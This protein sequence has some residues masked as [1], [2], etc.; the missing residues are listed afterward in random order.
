MPARPALRGRLGR[1]RRTCQGSRPGHSGSGHACAQA[2]L[3]SQ[4]ARAHR[5]SDPAHTGTVDPRAG[6]KEEARRPRAEEEGKEEIGGRE[7]WRERGKPSAL[8]RD[9]MT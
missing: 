3:R 8:C 4:R 9:A 1:R 6:E 7:G 2:F 5:R